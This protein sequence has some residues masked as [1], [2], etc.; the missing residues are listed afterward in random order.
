MSASLPPQLPSSMPRPSGDGAPAFLAPLLK[1]VLLVCLASA[2]M[3]AVLALVAIPLSGAEALQALLADE[4][5]HWLPGSLRWLLTHPVL[6]NVLLCV[7]SLLGSAACWGMLRRWRWAWALFIVLLAVTAVLNVIAAWLLDDAFGHLLAQ[8]PD[9][10]MSIELLKLRSEL[11][12]QRVICSGLAGMTALAF[13]VLQG[14]L[15]VRLCAAD[16]R[17]LFRR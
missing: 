15:I 6:A 14:W 4:E 10:T 2:A 1:S 13:A 3:W 16:V 12:V 8:I 9:D 11:R 5:L 17:A 7:S